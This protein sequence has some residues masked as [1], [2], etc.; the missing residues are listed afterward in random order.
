MN[1]ED[2]IKLYQLDSLSLILKTYLEKDHRKIHLKGL[3]G[4]QDAMVAATICHLRPQTHL[5][6][7]H[8]REEAFYFQ[9][10]L[11]NLMRDREVWFFPASYKKAYHFEEVENANVLQRAEVLNEINQSQAKDNPN[12]VI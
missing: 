8:D 2:I 10:D 5:F 9:N 7:L 4:S 3:I 11:Q 1:V 12:T 6:V